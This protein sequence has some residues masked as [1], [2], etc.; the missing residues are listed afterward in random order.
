[1]SGVVAGKEK[2]VREPRRAPRLGARGGPRKQPYP[3]SKLGS[4]QLV[5]NAFGL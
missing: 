4:D 5:I 1:M 3:T 2:T